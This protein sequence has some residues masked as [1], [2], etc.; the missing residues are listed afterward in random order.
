M[1]FC[2]AHHLTR[3]ASLMHDLPHITRESNWFSGSQFTVLS[4]CFHWVINHF[5]LWYLQ[6]I[7]TN[8]T[9]IKKAFHIVLSLP[10]C[11][12]LC[13]LFWLLSL[14]ST[15]LINLCPSVSFLTSPSLREREREMDIERNREWVLT[16]RPGS[17]IMSF[18]V[19]AISR[20]PLAQGSLA[21]CRN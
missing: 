15:F 8:A 1:W 4:F 5:E 20:L 10:F 12:P 18:G 14:P 16:H 17:L 7:L 19:N 3:N 9:D 2:R 6:G 21:M 11:L 13:L